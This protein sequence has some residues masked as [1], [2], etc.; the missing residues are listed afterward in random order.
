VTDMRKMRSDLMS[1]AREEFDLKQA[2]A[3][4]HSLNS[5]SR[6]YLANRTFEYRK[7]QPYLSFRSF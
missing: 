6:D 1:S 4:L 5:V 3:A 7:P 2:V